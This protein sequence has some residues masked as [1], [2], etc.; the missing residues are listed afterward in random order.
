M[1]HGTDERVDYLMHALAHE[2][3][4]LRRE[5]NDLLQCVQDMS[6]TQGSSPQLPSKRLPPAMP[7]EATGLSKGDA[8]ASSDANATGKGDDRKPGSPQPAPHNGDAKL[9][10]LLEDG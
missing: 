6:A 2:L 4:E 1:P 3:K 10:D 9:A 8:K 7:T 5:N